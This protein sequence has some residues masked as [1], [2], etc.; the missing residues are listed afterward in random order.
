M[1]KEIA[2]YTDPISAEIVRGYLEAQGITVR[3]EQEGAARVMGVYLG[4]FGEIALLVP[5]S[6]VEQALD[7]L[8]RLE[9]GEEEPP[10]PEADMPNG[11]HPPQE[12]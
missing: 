9:E 1:W 4:P 2:R 8:R 3:L 5:E 10:K 11:D 7:L 12:A 6:Q